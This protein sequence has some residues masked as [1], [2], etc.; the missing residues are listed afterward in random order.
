MSAILV[1]DNQIQADVVKAYFRTKQIE[2]ILT[3]NGLEALEMCKRITPEFILLDIMLPD[4]P[5]Y[6]VIERIRAFEQDRQLKP[7]PIFVLSALAMPGV[8]ERCLN[9]GANEY[10]SKP[11]QLALLTAKIE[12]YLRG[13]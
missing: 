1:E 9:S 4:I 11:I 2:C 13:E 10:F 6:E 8:R 12:E 3:S 5:G 7:V